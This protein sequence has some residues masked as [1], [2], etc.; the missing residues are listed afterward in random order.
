MKK[1]VI[2][3]VAASLS[4]AASQSDTLKSLE[5]QVKML[6]AQIQE[7]KADQEKLKNSTQVVNANGETLS[8][9]KNAQDIKSIRTDLT[10]VKKQTSGDHIKF[11]ADLRTAYDEINYKYNGNTG[12]KRRNG[13]WTNKLILGM[14]AAP[15]D[16]L[17]FRGSVGAYKIYGQNNIANSSYF[18]NFDW[19]DNQKPNDTAL[20]IREAYF[21]Y[22][23]E[24]GSVPYTVSFGRR[25]STDGFLTNL[26]ADNANP[27]SPI[28]HNINMEFDGASFK[29]DLDKLTNIPG[30]Y[31][32][33]CLGRGFSDTM[34]AYSMNMST[35]GFN[36]GYV[37]DDKNPNM[38]LAGLILQFYDDG[39]YKL[40]GNYFVA[41]NL[42]DM[43]IDGIAVIPKY[44]AQGRMIGSI[45][46]PSFSF[47]DV[48]DMTG[49]A[50]SL[51]V[52]GIGDGI[53]DFLDDSIFF[54]SFAFSK[55]KP[56]NNKLGAITPNGMGK[57]SGML[58][59]TDGKFG[60]SLYVGL[61]IPGFFQKDRIGFEYNHGSKY[62]RSFTYG[63]DTLIGSKLAARGDAYETYYILPIVDKNFTAQLSFLHIDY[64]YTGSDTFFGWTGT[65]M[66][67]DQTPG[68]VK[69]AQQIRASLRYRY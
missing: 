37:N 39:Q 10:D 31:A 14:S 42:M 48:G 18:Q 59:S 55:T 5:E 33:L 1:L 24:M 65:P 50:L 58:G 40:L 56:N 30:F 21:L 46:R 13:I 19:Y 6:Q 60:S 12:K 57:V 68:A 62:W 69:K 15:T 3:S 34:G 29:F 66:D 11:N 43:D 2:L 26:R 52:N 49:G 20:R 8:V 64:D 16:N 25:P 53:S 67:V 27:N 22:M 32:K 35:M 47:K 61:Q 4:M 23:N 44:D 51:Q 7:L 17:V 38:D 9:A 28:G 36:P 54:A 63:E 45:N 41:K